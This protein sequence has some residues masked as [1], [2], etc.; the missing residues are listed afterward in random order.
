MEFAKNLVLQ[1]MQDLCGTRYSRGD[2]A[3]RCGSDPGSILLEGQWAK[4]KR[5][6]AKKN[7][8][9]I[10]LKSYDSLRDYDL[11][12]DRVM[13]HMMEGVSTRH[14]EG[15]LKEVEDGTGL[16]HSAVSRAFMKGSKKKLEEMNSRS[17]KEFRFVAA[18]L[19]GV[20]IGE[21][22]V[23][24]ALGINDKGKKMILGTREGDSENSEVVK[25]LMRSLMERG[26]STQL[27]PLFVLDG[28][29][30]LKKAIKKFFGENV[31]IQRCVRHKE[32]NILAYL[33]EISHMEFRR[34]WKKLHGLKDYKLALKEHESL[35]KFLGEYSHEAV[36]S[37]VE[38][39]MET[40]TVVK[41]GL[42]DLLRKS[43]LSTNPIES[44]F[45][46]FRRITHRITNWK[47]SKT[48]ASR[49][50]ASCLLHSE[51]SFRTIKGFKEIP[52]LVKALQKF[53]LQTE[54]EAA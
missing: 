23:I 32:R 44:P 39:N 53:N 19:D 38:A 27:I 41:L 5:P 45:N 50:V 6:R 4:F 36:S 48:Q 29:K 30:A 40:L 12:S 16:S 37:L 17:L 9:E 13:A 7:G 8:K 33:P 28:S 51:K 14:Y 52:I 15:L 22:S 49:W 43:L 1:E 10:K 11:L 46:V 2:T 20:E 3:V 42:P 35:L 25:D 34:R 26:L 54:L 47:S 18:M 24:V 31:F 21:K